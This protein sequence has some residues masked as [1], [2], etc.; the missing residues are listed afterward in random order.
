VSMVIH[1]DFVKKR[2]V[3]LLK[4]SILDSLPEKI[5]KNKPRNIIEI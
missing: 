2:L 3:E 1:R 5:K 4:Q